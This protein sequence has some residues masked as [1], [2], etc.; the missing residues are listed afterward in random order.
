MKQYIRYPSPEN[1]SLFAYL[2]IRDSPVY[3]HLRSKG[4]LDGLLAEHLLYY[5]EFRLHET[6]DGQT[7]D[8]VYYN[9]RIKHKSFF[10]G[11]PFSNGSLLLSLS[12]CLRRP[13]ST[14]LFTTF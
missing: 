2:E 11:L 7:P 13:F 3:L 6:I 9:R 4:R 14:L 1:T 10:S 5:N 12:I 8:A